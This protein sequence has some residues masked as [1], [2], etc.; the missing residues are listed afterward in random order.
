MYLKIENNMKQI[1]LFGNEFDP[2]KNDQK[3][4]SKINNLVYEPKNNKPLIHELFDDSK[5]KR[6]IKEIKKSN[7]SD[8]EKYFLIESAKRHVVF[9]YEKIA[10]Y[11][12]H[13]NKEMQELMEKLA[14]V[15]IDF[16]KAI[17]LG[18][19]KLSDDLKKQYLEQYE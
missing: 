6:L 15:I 19:V 13:S 9:N 3:Y 8:D 16:N 4:T 17:Q 18:Y 1:N 7:I 5:T 14:L 11:Y 12:S 2:K 10:D